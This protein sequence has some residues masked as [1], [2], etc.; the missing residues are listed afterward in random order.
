MYCRNCGSEMSDNAAVCVKCGVAKDVASKYC[1][2]C[3]S[4]THELAAVCTSCGVALKR[5]NSTVSGM[6]GEKSK[7]VAGLLAIFLGYLGLHFFY[8]GENKKAITR[9]IFT[10]ISVLTSV[11]GLGFMCFLVVGCFNIFE[12]VKIFQGKIKD[13]AG[14]DL[15]D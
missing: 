7:L 10:V 8:L 6:T 2:N 4:E 9:I 12:A 13:A 15:K 1:P 5:N 3:G 14:N 11:I